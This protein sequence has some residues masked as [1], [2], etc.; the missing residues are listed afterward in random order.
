MARRAS[1]VLPA[2]DV[3]GS[4]GPDDDIAAVKTLVNM[5]LTH[6]LEQSSYDVP[7]ALNRLLKA[8]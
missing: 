7:A 6:A 3:I 8:V 2:V 5:E 4:A 1:R